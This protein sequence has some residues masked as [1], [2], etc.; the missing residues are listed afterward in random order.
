MTKI[1]AIAVHLELVKLFKIYGEIEDYKILDDYPSEEFTDTILLKFAK[2][3]NA[4]QLMD[5]I[6]NVN[7]KNLSLFLYFVFQ[8]TAKLKLDNYNFFGKVLHVCY[9]PEF[10]SIDDVR[11]KINERKFIVSFKCKKYGKFLVQDFY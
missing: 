3:Q 11:Q 6:N 10:E 5:L 4:R 2:I 8:R 9:A 1:P 7:I